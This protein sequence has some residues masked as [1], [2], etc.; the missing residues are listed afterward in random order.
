MSIYLTVCDVPGSSIAV[1]LFRFVMSPA[2]LVAGA[3]RSSNH[4]IPTFRLDKQA[5]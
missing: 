4:I 1:V 5:S 3:H 2:T